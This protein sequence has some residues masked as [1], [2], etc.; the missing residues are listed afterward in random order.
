MQSIRGVGEMEFMF[1]LSLKTV[2]SL[3]FFYYSIFKKFIKKV[4]FSST[5]EFSKKKK[6]QKNM[7]LMPSFPKKEEHI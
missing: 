5:F 7:F 6:F 4:L 2:E 1:C 3:F